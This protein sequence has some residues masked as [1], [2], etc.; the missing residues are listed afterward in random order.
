MFDLNYGDNRKNLNELITDLR[1]HVEGRWGTTRLNNYATVDWADIGALLARI[2][3]LEDQVKKLE[4]L[5]R[6]GESA[7]FAS[8]VSPNA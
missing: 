7:V 2:D 6:M 4:G 5:T 1:A 3:E 8:D